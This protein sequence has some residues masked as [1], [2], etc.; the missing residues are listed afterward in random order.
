MRIRKWRAEFVVAA[1]LVL[2]GCD[3]GNVGEAKALIEQQLIDPNSV[4]YDSIE[5]Y[6][7]GVVCGNVNAKNR[8]GGFTGKKAFLYRRG[9]VE[10]DPSKTSIDKYCTNESLEMQYGIDFSSE[11]VTAVRQEL[12]SLVSSLKIYRLDNYTFPTTEQ[13]LVALVTASEIMP[14]PRNFKKGGYLYRLVD[15]NDPWGNPYQY[16][17]PGS[18]GEIDVWSF[19]ADGIKGGDGDNADIGNWMFD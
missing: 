6:S 19:G 16:Q 10:F 14:E 7:N 3:S 15:L 17:A 9:V 13:G 2:F 18:N 1:A 5:S 8:M 12:V 4:Q 11:S